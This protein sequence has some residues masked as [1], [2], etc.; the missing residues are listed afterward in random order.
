MEER[1]NRE[2]ALGGGR[3]V[4]WVPSKLSKLLVGTMGWL[5][6]SKGTSV[7]VPPH[8]LGARADRNCV[9]LCHRKGCFVLVR[10]YLLRGKLTI[11]TVLRYFT[12]LPTFGR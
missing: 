12:Y 4:G 6:P 5:R 8:Q 3:W 9:A 7:G 2:R 11:G 10:M 1:V